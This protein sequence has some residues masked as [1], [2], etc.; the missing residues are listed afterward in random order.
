[1]GG[2]HHEVQAHEYEHLHLLHVVR[3]AGDQRCG[4]ELVDVLCGERGDIQEHPVAQVPADGHGRFRAEIDCGD[5]RAHLDEG[6]EEHHAAGAPNEIRVTAGNAFIDDLGVEA[7]QVE[8]RNG[9]RQLKD[10]ER[11]RCTAYTAWNSAV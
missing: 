3:A 6:N 9:G 5:G 11:P 2:G 7:G 4:P 8:R 10:N 1:M